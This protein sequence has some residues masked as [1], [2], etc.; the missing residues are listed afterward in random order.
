VYDWQT[1][2]GTVDPTWHDVGL[3]FLTSAANLTASQCPALATAPVDSN[4]TQVIN[5]GRVTGGN[6]SMT[7]LFVGAPVSVSNS[8]QYPYDY[9]STDIIEEG[10]SGGPDEVPGSSPH[11]IVAVNSGA[12]AGGGV[13]EQVLARID[14]LNSS[15]NDW[16]QQQITMHGGLGVCA[17]TTSSGSSSGSGSGSSSSSSSGSS[18]SGGSGGSSG[19]SS[20]GG[21]SGS[22]AGSSG[23]SG[24]PAGSGSTSG[25]SSDT[26]SGW[27]PPQQPAG[28]ACRA[29]GSATDAGGTSLAGLAGLAIAAGALARRRARGGLS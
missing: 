8:L 20:G 16:I 19:G 1:N 4:T 9:Q 10:D 22:V 18:S 21:S 17:S 14:L 24:S 6:P 25:G 12:G 29:S 2:D 3:V 11:L 7:D 13:S 23:S 15:A 26:S 5:I 28:C 27:G